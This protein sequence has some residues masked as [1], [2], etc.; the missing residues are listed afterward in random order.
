MANNLD[1]TVIIPVHKLDDESGVLLK[2]AIQSVLNQTVQVKF[3]VVSPKDKALSAKIEEATNDLGVTVD[4]HVHEGDT[5][6]C[7]QVNYGVSK[8]DTEYFSILEL[9]DEYAKTYF[10]NVGQYI[11]A[12]GASGYLPITIVVDKDNNGLHY[13][14]EAVWASGF[15]EKLGFLDSQ[16]LLQYNNFIISGGVFKKAAFEEVGG[17]RK[18]IKLYFNYEFL[19]RYIHNDYS[20]MVIPKMGYKHM[21][22][23]E[24]S[25]FV[26]YKDPINGIKADEARFYLDSAKREYFFNPNVIKRELKYSVAEGE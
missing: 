20:T 12:Y 26:Q 19:L 17:L 2:S 10:A 4:V 6:F 11:E 18:D 3:F 1:I 5:D 15:S 23:R 7:S 22:D 14:N 16:S 21:F 25:L 13:I 9:D 24:D 8:V